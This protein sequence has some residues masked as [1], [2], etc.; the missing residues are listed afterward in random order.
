MSVA[1]HPALRSS[2]ALRS[3]QAASSCTPH[4][5]PSTATLHPALLTTE[6]RIFWSLLR[7]ALRYLLTW[8]RFLRASTCTPQTTRDST[9]ALFVLHSV[10][11]LH[12]PSSSCT[13]YINLIDSFILHYIQPCQMHRHASLASSSSHRTK[14]VTGASDDASS[15]TPFVTCSYMQS[16]H[17]SFRPRVFVLHS[18]HLLL[19]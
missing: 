5:K 4:S 3:Q 16:T 12:A 18:V 10:H 15:C 9:G 19:T 13:P 11:Q 17:D 14:L 7:P 8:T 2:P 6:L 1:L